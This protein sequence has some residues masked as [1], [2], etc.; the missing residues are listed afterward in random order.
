MDGDGQAHAGRDAGRQA[1]SACAAMTS[2]HRTCDTQR[3]GR[4]AFP[5]PG[6]PG[7]AS[8]E[9][10]PHAGAVHRN[11]HQVLYDNAMEEEDNLLAPGTCT[12]PARPW[13]RVRLLCWRRSF[14][15]PHRSGR[16]HV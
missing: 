1:G 13:L 15:W 8:G 2:S 14:C 10:A 6:T 16:A 3:G 7:A 9:L 5:M 11:I 12:T 4:V